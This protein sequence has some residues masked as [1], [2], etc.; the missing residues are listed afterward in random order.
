MQKTG[1]FISLG[2]FLLYW[3]QSRKSAGKDDSKSVLETDYSDYGINT[4]DSTP[5]DGLTIQPVLHI[6]KI[7]QGKVYGRL[8]LVFTYDSRKASNAK[9]EYLIWRENADVKIFD[10]QFFYKNKNNIWQGNSKAEEILLRARYNGGGSPN[11]FIYDYD[12]VCEDLTGDQIN[13]I[14][15]AISNGKSEIQSWAKTDVLIDYSP[16]VNNL[17]REIADYSLEYNGLSLP[18][19]VNNVKV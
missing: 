16:I 3:W 8:R 7:K 2:L 12:G 1:L 17:T 13:T 9:A 10:K 14:L 15:D 4:K 11:V 19:I 18:T 6:T 5:I